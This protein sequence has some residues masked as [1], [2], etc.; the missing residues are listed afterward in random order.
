MTETL[1]ERNMTSLAELTHD[2][3]VL[4]SL[5]RWEKERAN[6][7]FMT[8]PLGGGEVLDITWAEAADQAR[9]MASWITAQGWPAG[10]N[11]AILGKNSA[12]WILADLAIWMAGHVSVPIYPTFNADAL[13]YILQHSESKACFI[14]KLDDTGALATGVP[15]DCLLVTLPLAPVIDTAALAWDDLIASNPPLA[16]E[17]HRDG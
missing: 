9:R 6:D 17:P 15:S 8:Q 10:S 12:H 14:G 13:R 1:L 11:M 3:F 16:G 2:D 5:Y 4:P 7:V